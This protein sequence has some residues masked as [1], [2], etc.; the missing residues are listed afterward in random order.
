MPNANKKAPVRRSGRARM[1]VLVGVALVLLVGQLL[2][3]TL[4]ARYRYNLVD[5]W[6]HLFRQHQLAPRNGGKLVWTR[7]GVPYLWG[8]SDPSQDFDISEFRLDPT[9]LHYGLGR[10]SFPALIEP[11][12]VSV[13]EARTWP[14][15]D[16]ESVLIAALGDEVKIYPTRLLVRHEVVND[17]IGGRPVFAAYCT[18]A[19][20]GAIYDRRIN[21]HTL[22]FAVS[23]YTYADPEVWEGRDAFVLW[24]RDT[25]SLWWPAIG[26]AVSGPLVDVPMKV[27]DENLWAQTNWAEAIA[28]HPG[29]LVLQRGQSMN[30]PSTDWPRLEYSSNRSEK[31]QSPAHRE[32]TSALAASQPEDVR[33][34]PNAIAPH[35]GDNGLDD[36]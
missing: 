35:W 19:N 5:G 26:K 6:N 7:K 36:Q 3:I 33:S 17:V 10:E 28:Q 21:G 22:T 29:A 12:F 1:F 30:I 8:G 20:L 13:A 14:M 23:G 9:G 11:K 4:N 32:G 25:E 27:L 34:T 31:G 2:A 15:K 16:D 24:D 18:L